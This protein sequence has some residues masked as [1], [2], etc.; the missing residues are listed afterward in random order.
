MNIGACQR[1]MGAYTLARE[2]LR[3]ALAS[4][5][6]ESA[7]LPD[8]LSQEAGAFI[9]EIDGIVGH[10]KLTISPA[11]ASIAVDGRPVAR[12][13]DAWIAGI[14]TPSS[15]ERVAAEYPIR[16]EV[17]PGGHVITVVRRGFEEEV[18]AITV[19]PA[20]DVDVSITMSR[21]P[22]MLHVTSQPEGAL[23]RMDGVE[24][25][26]TPVSVKRPAGRYGI[27]LTRN[28]FEPH[29]ANVT[30][31][32][33]EEA[34]FRAELGPTRTPIFKQWWFWTGVGVLVTGAAVTTYALTR[35]A[36]QPDG[37]GLGWSIPVR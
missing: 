31:Q 17:N 20:S 27:V 8:A 35:P 37:G 1:S 23:A 4:S 11:D 2:T 7:M 34:N 15:P 25:G 9:R 22:A 13:H 10:I 16:V 19:V 12:A 30:V 29:S 6:P 5:S 28:G 3:K 26:K 14:R 33:G 18:R 36:P 24:L 21:L 32:P